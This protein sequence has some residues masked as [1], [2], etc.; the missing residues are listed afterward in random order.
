MAND[1]LILWFNHNL[2]EGS[3]IEIEP[4]GG[5]SPVVRNKLP[6]PYKTGKH[7][8]PRTYSDAGSFGAYY[9][10][11]KYWKLWDRTRRVGNYAD[12]VVQFDQFPDRFVFWR[13]ATNVPHWVNE[14]NHWYNNEFIERRGSDYGLHDLLEPMSDYDSRFSYVQIIHNSSA[15]TVIHWR[16]T[17][18]TAKGQDAFHGKRGWGDRVDIYYYI[19]PDETCVEYANLYTSVPNKF[20]EWHEAIPI[21]NPGS[22]PEDVIE[23]NAL[24]VADE[25]GDTLAYN[26][27]SGFPPDSSFKDGY[28]IVK[29]N[30]KG[31]SDPF[32]ISESTHVWWDPI[33]RPDDHR[34][35][36]YD[37]WPG[38]PKKF[39]GRDWD[40]DPKTGYKVYSKIL[41]SQSSLMHLNWDNYESDYSGPYYHLS[42]VLLNGMSR[43]NSIKPLVSLASYWEDPPLVKVTGYGYSGGTFDKKQKAYVVIKRVSWVDSLIDRDDDKMPNKKPDELNLKVFATQESPVINP[44]FVVHNWSKDIKC[45]LFINDK[46]ASEGDDFKQGIEKKW[47]KWSSTNTLVLW[48][49]DRANTT[50]KYTVK[51]ME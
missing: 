11:L 8:L 17:P 36:Q 27:S 38:W 42:R 26:F 35:N 10:T 51:L 23:M 50:V 33:S 2:R 7:D 6:N 39:R 47:E 24:K 19:Y 5:N 21:T 43:Q 49:K 41:P 29:V 48:I 20:H 46:E 3:T 1:N 16:Y 37:D 13:G 22:F 4:V 15:R 45:K 12:V 32:A 40:V 25:S 14:E 28:N 31:R 18:V 44:V 34:F 9:K 30:L